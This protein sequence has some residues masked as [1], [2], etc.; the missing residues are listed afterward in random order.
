MRIV[1]CG[2]VMKPYF[3]S[4]DGSIQI[5][6]GDCRDVLPTLTDVGAVITDPPYG[7]H[8]AAWDGAVPYDLV[9]T[10]HAMTAGP[11]LWFGASPMLRTDLLAFPVPPQRILVWA[12]TFSLSKTMANGLAYRWHP[13]YA[14][15]LPK[16]HSGPT[17][18]VL[19][20]PTDGRNFWNHPATKPLRL[21][22]SLVGI[23]PVGATVLDPF[24]GS[25]TTLRAAMDLGR[26]AIGVEISEAYCEI[27][28]KRLQQA[29]LPLEAA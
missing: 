17:W 8:I 1:A 26:K 10:F 29:V 25:G 14:W 23:S 2:A 5:F 28:A 12:P 16:S 22:R 9:T 18:D 20:T 11:I 21:M 6:H 13:L 15:Q 7:V 19:T 24:M 4:P 27:A 3:E